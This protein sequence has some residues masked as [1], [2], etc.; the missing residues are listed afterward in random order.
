V[1]HS[2]GAVVRGDCPFQRLR[3]LCPGIDQAST[4]W[5]A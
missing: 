2:Q 1:S 3:R 5:Q 4:G